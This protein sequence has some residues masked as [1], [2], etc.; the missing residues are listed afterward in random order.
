MKLTKIT[1]FILIFTLVFSSLAYASD[2]FTIYNNIETEKISQGITY[3]HIEKLSSSGWINLNIIRID[4]TNK[5]TKVEPVFNK[6]GISNRSQL[7]DILENNKASAGINGDFFNMGDPSFPMGT[8]IKD[9]KIIS[10]PNSPFYEYPTITSFNDNNIDISIWDPQINVKTEN[11]QIF[12]I[13]AVN[14]MVSMSDRILIFNRSW[15]KKTIGST[16]DRQLIEIVVSNNKVKDIRINKPATSIP[17]N[18]YVIVTDASKADE[19]KSAFKK[20]SRVE[21]NFNFDIDNID[22]AAGGVNFLVREGELYKENNGVSGRHPR[23]AIGYNED[24]TEMLLVTVDG[25]NK[26]YSGVT[27]E[28][29]ANI[30]IELGAYEAVNMDG[31]GSTSMGVDFL[32][33]GNIEVVNFPSDGSERFI[34]SGLGVF[35]TSPKSSRIAHLEI[36]PNYT[37]VFKDTYVY[38]DIKAY[39]KYYNSI[40]VNS[41]KVKLKAIGKGKV[42]GWKFMPYESGTVKIQAYYGN[43]KDT[44]EITVLDEPVDIIFEN[45]NLILD[46]GEKYSLGNILGVD[47]NGN[48]ANISPANIKWSYRNSVGRVD[49]DG[50]FTASSTTNTGAVIARFG[51]A[52]EIINVKVGYQ[53]KLIENFDN[54]DNLTHTVYPYDSEGS[55]EKS[56]RKKEGSSS[57]KLNYDFTKMTDQ[58]IA[59]VNF[60]ENGITLEGEPK[61]IGMWV[62]GDGKDHWLRYRI[63]DSNGTLYYRN[64]A[65]EVDWTGWKWVTGKFPEDISYPVTLKNIYIAEINESMKDKGSIYIDNLKALYEPPDKELALSDETNFEDSLKIDSIDNYNYSLKIENGYLYKHTTSEEVDNSVF[66]DAEVLFMD[67]SKGGILK[68]DVTQWETLLSIK[69]HKDMKIII[70]LNKKITSF[71][72]QRELDVF[73]EMVNDLAENNNVFVVYEGE[74]NNLKIDSTV[75]YVE[76]LNSF[77]LFVSNE[78]ISYNYN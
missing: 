2:F 33:T 3:E 57:I 78:G 73:K 47:I 48:T 21:L 7:E 11:G 74:E 12:N 13:A 15:S 28:E 35:N 10:S 44:V 58:S 56:S 68:T 27:Q 20:Y 23:S 59:F 63:T 32:R 65:V 41:S 24:K 31:G 70:S 42:S 71:T 39:D 45:D 64:F 18:G 75:R 9:G 72:D 55:I 67:I 30:M 38:F 54:L 19:L 69:D 16:K 34:D 50:V 51:D 26:S 8:L 25:R 4:L 77:E 17:Y 5:Y 52:V 1:L 49:K 37:K 62:Y 29:L 36:I 43:I 14:K 60:N 46:N 61:G 66:S 6:N 76:Y 40:D 22:W 53:T